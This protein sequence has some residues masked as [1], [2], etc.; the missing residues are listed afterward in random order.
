MLK[1]SWAHGVLVMGMLAAAH[2]QAQNYQVQY[3]AGVPNQAGFTFDGF[4]RYIGLSDRINDA[5]QLAIEAHFT[6]DGGEPSSG[7][8]VSNPDGSLRLVVQIGDAVPGDP[9]FKFGLMFSSW[10]DDAGRVSF[11][12]IVAD[13][14]DDPG[15]AVADVAVYTELTPGGPLVEVARENKVSPLGGTWDDISAISRSTPDG[16]IVFFNSTLAPDLDGV[17]AYHKDTQTYRNVMRQMETV[18][19]GG[20]PIDGILDPKVNAAG[21]V[22]FLGVLRDSVDRE[23]GYYQHTPGVGLSPLLV[24]EQTLTADGFPLVRGSQIFNH[25]DL[26]ELAF[27]GS[28]MN[29]DTNTETEAAYFLNGDGVLVELARVGDSLELGSSATINRF[30]GLA[31]NNAGQVLLKVE[32]SNDID[33]LLIYD[34]VEGTELIASTSDFSWL[35]NLS[36]FLELHELTEEGQALFS[37]SADGDFE[38]FY[39]YDPAHGVSPIIEAGELIDGVA[40]VDVSYGESVGIINESGL[41]G[42]NS[43]G[44]GVFTFRLED[45]RTGIA[46]FTVPEPGTASLVMAFSALAL[47]RRRRAA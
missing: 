43:R 13:Q 31:M 32:D 47:T 3:L 14:L 2:S 22:M 1:V 41:V 6:P 23:F 35:A 20:L 10:I 21:Q 25:N 15:T 18:T 29:T 9:V 45:E 16:E 30:F 28:F 36:G 33:S 37:I 40:V 39:L 42:V 4:F 8:F 11:N 44:Q 17:T 19:P 12:A 5:G 38:G 34:P 7:V 46:R 26:G 24:Y 27:V